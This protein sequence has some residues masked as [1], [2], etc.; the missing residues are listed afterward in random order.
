M[1]QRLRRLRISLLVLLALTTVLT[2]TL[3]TPA[4]AVTDR[5]YCSPPWAE[6]EVN[7]GTGINFIERCEPFMVGTTVR[8]WVWT[9]LRFKVADRDK[10]TIAS[11]L[12]SSPPYWMQIQ[13]LSGEALAA[14]PSAGGSGS[15]TPTARTLTD[16]SL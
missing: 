9:F 2:T 15:Q 16:A 10:R 14:V 13:A 6:R 11:R 12:S 3:A 1:R 7:T 8:V 5:Y 4:H